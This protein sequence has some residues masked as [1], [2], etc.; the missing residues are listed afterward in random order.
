MIAVKIWKSSLQATSGSLLR[1][2]RH[3]RLQC[4]T[5]TH[6]KWP[7]SS[8]NQYDEASATRSLT[9][10]AQEEKLF[11]DKTIQSQEVFKWTQSTSS[12]TYKKK[13]DP[14]QAHTRK[15]RCSKCGDSKHVEG[16]KCPAKK[17]QCKTC[18]KYAHFTSLCYKKSVSLGPEHPRCISYKVD[19]CTCKKT[20]YVA[21]QMIWPPAMS[22]FVYKW[23]YNAHK[24]VPRFH[25]IS[26]YY[27]LSLKLK[28]HHT[29][30]QY[31]RLDT[32][33]N[34]NIMPASVYKLVF[35]D[36]DLKKLAPSKLKIGT[37][38]TDTVKLV[39]SC[40]FYLAHPDTKHLQ[41]VTFYVASGNGSVLLSCA[42]ILALVLI[43]PHTRLDYLPPRSSLITN[44]ADHPK[45]TKSQVNVH[46][47]KKESIVSTVSNWQ[48]TVHK[49][50]T[51]KDQILQV[52]S[53]VFAGI[54]H[55]P[56]PPYHI[57]VDPSVT[58]KQ[59]PC[60]PVPVYLKE[61]F[62]QEIDKM[63]QAGVLKPF[64]QATPWINSFVLV[65]GKI[66]LASSNWEFVLILPI[67]M[68]L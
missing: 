31:L 24:L 33:A 36:P 23:K 6:C 10:Q 56:G 11:Q 48:G 27:Q 28:P 14:K 67:W 53:D 4:V 55:F 49:L 65:E 54:G 30:N 15:D 60:W 57:Q 18:N 22:P 25:N 64:H 42:T 35:Q 5:S 37:Y 62:K 20:P 38:T 26:S 13:F 44:C 21:S 8:P 51:C 68:K 47:S 7:P 19:K 50:T 29:R 43:Q 12:A 66:S 9:K 63:L 16:F 52:Y 32:C 1:R 46:V 59:T 17:F 2:W 39:G 41:E 61:P 40:L 45:K 58:P 3:Q 34:V